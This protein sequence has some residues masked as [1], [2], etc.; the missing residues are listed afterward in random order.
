MPLSNGLRLGP[1]VILAPLGAGGMGDVGSVGRWRSR[2]SRRR[3]RV[4]VS[5][6]PPSP[7]VLLYRTLIRA[8]PVKGWEDSS[9]PKTSLPM[10][11]RGVGIGYNVWQKKFA[12]NPEVLGQQRDSSG[13]AAPRITSMRLKREALI[14]AAARVRPPIRVSPQVVAQQVCALQSP[15]AL[16]E[17]LCYYCP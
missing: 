2:R 8:A 9:L 11:L 7:P 10:R 5:S 12:D 14:V 15:R 16:R 3:S 1:Y 13:R 4:R 17:Q 6:A